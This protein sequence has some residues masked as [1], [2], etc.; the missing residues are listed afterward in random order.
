M[1]KTH[2]DLNLQLFAEDTNQQGDPNQGNPN[3]DEPKTIE[4]LTKAL[5]EQRENSVSRE[6]YN[7]VLEQNNDLTKAIIEGKTI[8]ADNE[9]D[10]KP[11]DLK[12]LA[13]DIF[14]DGLSNLEIAK[15][16]LKYRDEVI[17]QTGK[18]PFAP[19]HAEMTANDS[20]RAEAVAEVMQ[21]CINDC[22]GNPEVYNALFAQRIEK[23]SPQMVATL[24][25]KGLI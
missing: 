11:A 24:K 20:D 10:E 13:K 7:K 9:D 21:S 12:A 15:R 5:K 6:Q 8:H 4:A 3:P 14:Q 23:D 16:E 1:K 25:R 19:N 22:G 17:K 2:Y 18:D